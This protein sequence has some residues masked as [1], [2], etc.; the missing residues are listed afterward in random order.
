MS[1][2]NRQECSNPNCE[3]QVRQGFPVQLWLFCSQT[4]LEDSLGDVVP[5]ENARRNW[6]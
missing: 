1:H 3:A 6:K 4:C 2:K 5:P